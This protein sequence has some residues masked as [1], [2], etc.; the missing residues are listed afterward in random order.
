MLKNGKIVKYESIPFIGCCGHGV[1]GT[2]IMKNSY[3]YF[4]DKNEYSI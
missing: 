3:E 1:I 4:V 2:F